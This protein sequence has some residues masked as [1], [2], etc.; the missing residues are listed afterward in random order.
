MNHPNLK[1]QLNI[2][3][4][5]QVCL[6]FLNHKS[7]GVNFG[8]GIFLE[9]PELNSLESFDSEIGKKEK[10]SE[11]IENFYSNSKN[12]LE[13]LLINYQKDWKNIEEQFFS[14]TEKVFDK[15]EWPKGKYIC[16][17][18]IFNCNPRFLHNKTFQLFYKKGEKAKSTICHELL[19]FIFYH[20]VENSE[21]PE[22]V[23]W[24]VSEIF[25]TI[26][27]NQPEFKT[28]ITPTIEMGYPKHK[29]IIKESLEIWN[30]YKDINKWIQ[31]TIN[32]LE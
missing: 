19:H 31:E 25:N 4:D 24:D 1:F 2:S 16:H 11:Y 14:E 6:N 28:L 21:I 13:N 29:E 20:Y 32:L 23:K 22:N 17:L 30:K 18:S 9:H 7:A 8:A 12:E 15:T 26:I 10:I 27:L 3:L 5:K